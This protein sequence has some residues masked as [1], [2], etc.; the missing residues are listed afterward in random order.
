MIQAERQTAPAALQKPGRNSLLVYAGFVGLGLL[1]WL[2][3]LCLTGQGTTGIRIFGPEEIGMILLGGVGIWLAPRTGFPDLLDARIPDQQRFL[4]PFIIGLGF[5]GA[6]IAVF[7]LVMHPGP[8][9]EMMPFM[10]PFP[11][12]VL[13]YGSGALYTDTLYRLIPIPVLMWVG[14]KLFLKDAKNEHLFWGLAV[15]TSL[16]E[17]IDQL[18][19]DSPEL[20]LYSFITGYA[21]N[22]LQVLYFRQSGFLAGLM[23]RFGHY[24]LWHVLFGLW[25]ELLN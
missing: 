13:L 7:K 17:P 24:S 18:I 19:T 25:V 21:M 3:G 4:C 2:T 6:D 1:T 9:T 8:V 20:I 11:Y 16:I 10:Q 15:L 23:I 14:G 12:S 22:L 5:A